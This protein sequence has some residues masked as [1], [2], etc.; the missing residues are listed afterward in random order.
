[1]KLALDEDVYWNKLSG[2]EESDAD[3]SDSSSVMPHVRSVGAAGGIRG[4]TGRAAFFLSFFFFFFFFF[5]LVIFSSSFLVSFVRPS[6]SLLFLLPSLL[7]FV[8]SFC[9][10]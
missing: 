10:D 6:L 7:V 4:V 3:D 9:Q 5:F 2:D 8:T 1:M